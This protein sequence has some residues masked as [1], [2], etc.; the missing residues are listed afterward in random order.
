MSLDAVIL[1]RGIVA[2]SAVLLPRT[3]GK[4][5]RGSSSLARAAETSAEPGR[6]WS[7]PEKRGSVGGH[8]YT[9]WRERMPAVASGN[10]VTKKLQAGQV[11]IPLFSHVITSRGLEQLLPEHWAILP[12]G[13]NFGVIP[14][15]DPIDLGE[16]ER[17]DRIKDARMGAE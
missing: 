14:F 16:G 2:T 1:V 11:K 8:R 9:F 13:A 12:A 17:T 6:I 4:S 3:L 10:L 5:L 7:Q 15:H